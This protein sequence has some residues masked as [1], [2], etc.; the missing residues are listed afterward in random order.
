[1]PSVKHPP[2]TGNHETR[3]MA[4]ATRGRATGSQ[5]ACQRHCDWHADRA[6]HP[7]PFGH[8]RRNRDRHLSLRRSGTN[9]GGSNVELHLETRTGP[10]AP[11]GPVRTPQDLDTR[12]EG[13]D[14]E[15]ATLAAWRLLM[16]QL[17]SFAGPA[18]VFI[19]FLHTM[20]ALPE[21]P[22]L[23]PRVRLAS[24]GRRALCRAQRL[25]G[26]PKGW[27]RILARCARPRAASCQRGW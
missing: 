12:Y 11:A 19:G 24:H 10:R 9:V 18:S 16:E 7:R 21:Q 2:V 4:H 8:Y 26:E 13:A 14:I 22:L 23:Q 17:I 27:A 6:L 25:A 3:R 5:P 1:M 20:Q 15:L